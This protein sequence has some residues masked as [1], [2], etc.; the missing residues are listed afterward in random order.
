[1]SRFFAL[2]LAAALAASAAAA[3]PLDAFLPPQPTVATGGDLQPAFVVSGAEACA[4]ACLAN[5]SCISFSLD[6]TQQPPTKTCGIVEE[7]YAPNAT[8][9]PSFLTLSCVGG[10][11]TSVAFA[12][13]GLPLVEPGQCAFAATPNCSAPSSAD[14][15]ARAC[16]G[17]S[18]C[19]IDAQVATFGADPCAG[20]VKFLAAS[21]VGA[22]CSDQ[23]PP[24]A[25][26]TCTLSGYSRIYTVEP[27]NVSTRAYYQRLM[28]RNDAPVAQAV[29]YKLDVPR[30]GVSVREGHV[31]RT[32]F[33]N[34][35][36][37]LTQ[38]YTVDDVL[39]DFRKRAGNPSPPGACHGWDCTADWI[40]GSIAG[41]FLMGAGGHLRWE[42]NAQ[43]REMM[44]SVIDGIANCSEPDGYLAAFAQAK[45]ATDEHPDYT[46]SWTVHGFLEAA[47]AGNPKALPMIRAHSQFRPCA[48]PVRHAQ[49][50]ALP[51]RG[52]PSLSYLSAVNVFNNHTLIPTFLPPDGGNWPWQTPLGPSPPGFVNKSA[53]GGGTLT[54]HTVYL[55]VQGIIHNTRMALSPVGTQADV[56]LV[57]NLY[58]EPWWLQALAAR[59]LTVVG[60]KQWFSHN[61]QLTGIEAYLD[62]YALTGEQLYLDAVM[63]A[64]AM[65]RD[66]VLG[67]IDVGGSL[68]I[69]EGDIYEPGSF[70][71]KQGA[72]PNADGSPAVPA[73]RRHDWFRTERGRLAGEL[74]AFGNPVDHHHDH[75]HAHGH[76]DGDGG[77][78]DGAYPTGEFCGAVFWLKINQ[79]LHRHYPDNET[80]V[81]EM[82]REVYNEGLAHQ[83]PV[84][85]GVTTGIRYFSNMNGV[86]ENPGTIGTCCEGQGTRLYG[87]LYE[88]LFSLSPA[89]AP[90]ALY[91]DILAP[92]TIN[93]TAGAAAVSVQVVTDFPYG[94]SVLL[95]VSASP[96]GATFDLA[97]R[98][99][100]WTSAS[101]GVVVSIDG[102]PL[103]S[104]LPGTYLHTQQRAWPALSRVTYDLPP[105]VVAHRYT[106]VS[107]IAPYTRYTLTVGMVQMAATSATRY[108]KTLQGLVIPGVD[109]S[110]P[111]AWLIPAGDANPMHFAVLGV[112]DVLFQPAW[113]VNDGGAVFSNYPC[114][115][116]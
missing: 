67:W 43:L 91:V 56:D 114:F 116:L 59:D 24:P 87:S 45:L 105:A 49:Q 30:G 70:W 13:F 65:H 85:N 54:G 8:T 80:F 27:G 23:P 77:E 6:S 73:P 97:L 103:P 110:K 10:T 63:G 75:G 35:V 94:S 53:S 72:V 108:N 61:Y 44:D 38:H 76:G 37:Y 66:P 107:Q 16:V 115:D 12:S 60:E 74:D 104:A 92:S 26:L 109:G 29:P 32:A 99:P 3:S 34:G 83:G 112:Y 69:N 33:D 15:L 89:G 5:A 52:T 78:W 50:P 25:P 86:K 22:G 111:E 98:I 95:V 57:K 58:G 82:E 11:F 20:T 18:W 113:E 39:F 1:M 31:L 101:A 102:V 46:T 42:E 64:W 28:P 40:E 79:R 2:G 81:L 47:I 36:L 88:Y 55:I 14:V 17:K 9:C 4:A 48:A 71:L 84:V 68:M 41:L 96:P 7:C 51:F 19:S 106:G 93:F 62:M 21:L 100:A 90:P